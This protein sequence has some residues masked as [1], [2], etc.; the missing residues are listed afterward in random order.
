MKI[1]EYL[2]A[3]VP[4]T[5]SDLP[6]LLE[7][8]KDGENRLLTAQ[9]DNDSWLAAF[10]RIAENPELAAHIGPNDR[11]QYARQHTWTRRAEKTIEAGCEL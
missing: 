10:D 5:S 1:V 3:S 8:L 6:V 11:D 2:A 7:V 4:I 9:L